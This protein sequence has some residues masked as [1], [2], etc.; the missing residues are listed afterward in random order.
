ML[1]QFFPVPMDELREDFA[2]NIPP[3][4]ICA[5]SIHALVQRGIKNLY[6]SNLPSGAAVTT[7]GDIESRV[8]Q[9][10]VVS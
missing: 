5:R 3:E 9:M 2:A 8:E 10:V 6:V 4:E 1:A 7:L